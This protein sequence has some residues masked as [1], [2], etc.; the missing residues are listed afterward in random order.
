MT[1]VAIAV[2]LLMGG[3]VADRVGIPADFRLGSALALLGLT[4]NASFGKT[5]N[6]TVKLG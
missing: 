1:Q 2:G 5:A 4:A 3:M 6:N